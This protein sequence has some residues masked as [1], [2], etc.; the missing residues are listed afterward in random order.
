MQ[1]AAGLRI[2]RAEAAAKRNTALLKDDRAR[3]ILT[4]AI[5]AVGAIVLGQRADEILAYLL[6]DPPPR[7]EPQDD[8]G[9]VAP[10]A[11]LTIDVLANDAHATPEDAA[12]LRILSFPACGAAEIAANGVLYIANP[13]CSGRQIA[14]YCVRRGDLCP[15]AT[16]AID[17]APEPA[18]IRS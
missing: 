13:N 8:F 4:G 15:R 12:N 3:P 14:V 11:M 10:G 18:G 5:L 9:A 17:I 6:S 7:I 2:V 1:S 16:I